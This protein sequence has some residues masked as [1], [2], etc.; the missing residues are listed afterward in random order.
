MNRLVVR[1]KYTSRCENVHC[2]A[3]VAHRRLRRISYFKL[4]YILLVLDKYPSDCIM[5]FDPLC[6]M[7]GFFGSVIIL[8]V[9]Q[10][11]EMSNCENIYR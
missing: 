10:M 8:V 1:Y 11:D 9:V 5:F 6:H 3:I 2:A 7:G 4:V